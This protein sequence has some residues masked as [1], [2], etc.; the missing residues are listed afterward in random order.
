MLKDLKVTTEEKALIKK[1]SPESLP[2]NPTA[3]GYS[4]QEVRRLLYKALT[5]KEGSLLSLIENKMDITHD[6]I[7]RLE[8]AA[9][10][11]IISV[12]GIRGTNGN[13]D[14]IV[15]E[16]PLIPFNRQVFLESLGNVE[17]FYFQDSENET[18]FSGEEDYTL[19][20]EKE[21]QI[22]ESNYTDENYSIEEPKENYFHY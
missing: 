11:S 6:L 2:L 3:Q 18:E 20:E 19:P 16:E 15:T 7:E 10:D 22:D 5:G 14:T 4:G 13:V 8:T 12:N 9:W 1:N 17:Q 21:P